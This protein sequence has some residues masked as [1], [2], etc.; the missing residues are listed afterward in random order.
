MLIFIV[1]RKLFLYIISYFYSFHSAMPFDGLLQVYKTTLSFK[2]VIV[3]IIYFFIFSVI[4]FCVF[5]AFLGLF[6]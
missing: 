6:P 5:H 1:E 2:N 3:Y 4:P